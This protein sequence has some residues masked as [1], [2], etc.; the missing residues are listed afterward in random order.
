M[1]ELGAAE[2]RGRSFKNRD[3]FFGAISRFNAKLFGKHKFSHATPLRLACYLAL[4]FYVARE[5][6]KPSRSALRAP[7]PVAPGRKARQSLPHVRC[8][9]SRR[10]LFCGGRERASTA[11]VLP[12]FFPRSRASRA[13]YSHENHRFPCGWCRVPRRLLACGGR[14]SASNFSI[15]PRED[16]SVN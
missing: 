16:P 13:P 5:I 12:R 10:F 7:F 6:S 4:M 8:R 2:Q 1:R 14:E 15:K 11:E 3:T 9:V